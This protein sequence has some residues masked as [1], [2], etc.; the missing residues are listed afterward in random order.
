MPDDSEDFPEQRSLSEFLLG[1]CLNSLGKCFTVFL[2][3]RGK[4]RILLVLL[5][6]VTCAFIIFPEQQAESMYLYFLRAYPGFGPGDFSTY[7]VTVQLTTIMGT[8]GI[9]PLIR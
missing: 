5:Q 6:V 3:V 1:G 4:S 2:N 7:L 9:V 8:Q